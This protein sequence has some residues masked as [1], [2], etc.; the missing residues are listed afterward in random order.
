MGRPEDQNQRA[1]STASPAPLGVSADL[2]PFPVPLPSASILSLGPTLEDVDRDEEGDI[3]RQGEGL[4]SYEFALNTEID[5]AQGDEETPTTGGETSALPESIAPA[6]V[7]EKR[8]LDEQDREESTHSER[9]EPSRLLPPIPFP[10]PEPS[11][12]SAPQAL[13]PSYDV[14]SPSISSSAASVPTPRVPVPHRPTA[15]IATRLPSTSLLRLD[16]GSAS[17]PHSDQTTTCVLPLLSGRLVILGTAGGLR[18]LNTEDESSPITV[19]WKGLAVWE[20]RILQKMNQDQDQEDD[21]DGDV[22]R[23]NPVRGSVM[24]LCGGIED[25]NKPGKPK[26]GTGAEVRVYKLENLTSLA[27]WSSIQHPSYT[28][29]DLAPAPALRGAGKGKGKEGIEWI[30]FGSHGLNLG[31]S[32]TSLRTLSLTDPPVPP[33]SDPNSNS[34]PLSWTKDHFVLPSTASTSSSASSSSSDG[35]TTAIFTSPERLFVAIA[36]TTH[37]IIHGGFPTV[38]DPASCTFTASRS[39]YLPVPPSYV[40][41]LRL[42]STNISPN[43]PSRSLTTPLTTT[44]NR[45]DAESVFE[46]EDY[47]SSI[48]N[49]RTPSMTSSSTDP[50][51]IGEEEG[52]DGKPAELGLYVSFGSRACLIRITD[53]TVLDFKLGKSG[54]GGK[55]DWGAFETL[56]L[57]GGGEVYVMTRGKETFL[58]AAPFEI[59]SNC[60]TP[61]AQVLWPEAPLSISASVDYTPSPS[62]TSASAGR[63]DVDVQLIA[64]SF[65]GN[66]HVQHLTFSGT[67]RGSKTKPFAS[68]KIGGGVKILQ[69]D[70]S[71]RGCYLGYKKGTKDWRIVRLEK[72][73]S[74]R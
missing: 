73:R 58:F 7:D 62:S 2:V 29:I 34:L 30:K 41:F 18:L 70:K 53:S 16:Y 65:T 15:V 61:L 68:T 6:V 33:R 63:E 4:P 50:P 1:V 11:G 5:A 21:G 26:K 40:S 55:G 3:D 69:G 8:R 17:L 51:S 57:E 46:Y 25:P 32:P 22:Q 71:D 67:A 20:I 23:G 27:Q 52:E 64:T 13:P 47:A 19:I 74:G 49:G 14:A 24:V 60:N 10:Q 42:P 59:P 43:T 12:S 28:G 9:R 36:T 45:D 56:L 38:G 39:F 48:Y 54:S 35:L 44:T 37:I 31:P 72:D 66:I